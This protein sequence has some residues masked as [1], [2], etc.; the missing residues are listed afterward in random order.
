MSCYHLIVLMTIVVS[1]G[2]RNDCSREN[3]QRNLTVGRKHQDIFYFSGS[4][5]DLCDQRCENSVKFL[6]CLTL[7]EKILQS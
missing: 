6:A 5:P 2:D 7:Q 3:V 1:I 4:F